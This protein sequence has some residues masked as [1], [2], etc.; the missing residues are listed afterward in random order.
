MRK[1]HFPL[2]P[3]VSFWHFLRFR[4]V[5]ILL[6]HDNSV[7]VIYA[8]GLTF[9]SNCSVKCHDRC[10]CSV[11]SLGELFLVHLDVSCRVG[12]HVHVV[13]HLSERNVTAVCNLLLQHQFHQFLCRRAHI[14]KSLTERHYREP[15]SF[16]VLYHLHRSPPIER[17]LFY[18]IFR[19]EVFDK[20]LHVSVVDDIALRG[21]Y[22]STTE[23]SVVW[24]VVAFY[25]QIYRVFGY[26]KE[27]KYAVLPFC[28]SLS[29]CRCT[30]VRR[31]HFPCT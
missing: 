29:F 28:P 6:Y 13:H 31:P 2:T 25:S 9:V 26:P 14:L 23:P 1:W 30:L 19:T 15:H 17:N 3:K 21:D 22:L 11:D 16:Q 10:H 18:V 24:N 7:F 20:V 4:I 8:I 27:R 12:S 5:L